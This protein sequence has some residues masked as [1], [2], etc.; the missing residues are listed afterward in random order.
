MGEPTMSQ[1]ANVEDCLAARVI[2]YKKQRDELLK[3]IVEIKDVEKYLNEGNG[4][5]D[6]FI[7]RIDEAIA[8]AES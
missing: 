4:L 5:T 7:R 3:L 2:Y 6:D 1:F 8:K